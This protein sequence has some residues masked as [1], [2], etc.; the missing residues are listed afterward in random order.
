MFLIFT[1]LATFTASPAPLLL[2]PQSQQSRS[3]CDSEYIY[4]NH[5]TFLPA[6]V[7]HLPFSPD[8]TCKLNARYSKASTCPSGT[9][10]GVHRVEASARIHAEN[11]TGTRCP[12][13]VRNLWRRGLN[14]G[15]GHCSDVILIF[16]R[17]YVGLQNAMHN[18]FVI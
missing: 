15:Y 10:F 1:E 18:I 12:V 6:A 5:L 7:S 8:R 4:I 3:G 16:L 17:R 2:L 14:V 9:T 11:A 13:G